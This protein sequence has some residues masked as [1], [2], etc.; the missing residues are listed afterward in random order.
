LEPL[1]T[2]DQPDCGCTMLTIWL[3]AVMLMLP[4]TEAVAVALTV[5]PPP[6]VTD[7]GRFQTLP[8]TSLTWPL[9]TTAPGVPLSTTTQVEYVAASRCRPFR[10]T[11]AERPAPMAVT[12]D[13][14]LYASWSALLASAAASA[15]IAS[16]WKSAESLP[17]YTEEPY[18]ARKPVTSSTSMSWYELTVSPVGPTLGGW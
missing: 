13:C 7:G 10:A 8:L 5:P 12:G 6:M 3:G 18:S 4:V 1:L 14:W 15:T 16:N 11:R 9:T 17:R 2:P